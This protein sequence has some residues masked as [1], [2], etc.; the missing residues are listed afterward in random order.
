LKHLHSAIRGE[1]EYYIPSA[2]H[3]LHRQVWMKSRIF[4][5][6][7]QAEPSRLQSRGGHGIGF[8]TEYSLLRVDFVLFFKV[9]RI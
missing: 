1:V 8:F 9:R 4:K 3:E 2:F 6:F 5:L 7:T